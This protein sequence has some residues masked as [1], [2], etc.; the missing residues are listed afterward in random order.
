MSCKRGFVVGVPKY[1][2]KQYL[3]R[4]IKE[5]EEKR[6]FAIQQ[7]KFESSLFGESLFGT[8]SFE[9]FSSE[10]LSLS[11]SFASKS[12]D[13]PMETLRVVLTIPCKDEEITFV[14]SLSD[15]VLS[16]TDINLTLKESTVDY[17]MTPT[18]RAKMIEL[19][20]KIKD[21]VTEITLEMK[22]LPPIFKLNDVSFLRHFQSL[23][24]IKAGY[25]YDS[26]NDLDFLEK[27]EK[28]YILESEF[29]MHRTL[30]TETYKNLMSVYQKV[31]LTKNPQMF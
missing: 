4:K 11:E 22:N 21:E 27:L 7:A 2:A 30:N 5:N 3:E 16:K 31:T 23:K 19:L 14:E 1:A 15:E 29:T 9:T 28:I 6:K 17:V 12:L 8:S 24:T 10:T 20:S 25:C 26:F 18:E 13:T